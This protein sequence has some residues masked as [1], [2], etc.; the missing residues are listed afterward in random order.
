MDYFD[1]R[2]AARDGGSVLLFVGQMAALSVYLVGGAVFY[3]LLGMFKVTRWA[4]R[5]ARAARAGS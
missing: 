3:T 5:S 4:W 2:M 1:A